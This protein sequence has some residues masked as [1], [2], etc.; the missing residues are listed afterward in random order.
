MTL[1]GS[2]IWSK[3]IIYTHIIFYPIQSQSKRLEVLDMV[4]N[5][6]KGRDLFES[7]DW[8]VKTRR[9][10]SHN[11]QILGWFGEKIKMKRLYSIII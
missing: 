2:N 10:T 8:I 11:C 7:R 1:T 4:V 5:I 9:L 3:S 6:K